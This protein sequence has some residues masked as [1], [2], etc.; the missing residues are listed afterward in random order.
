MR[1]ALRRF[2][3]L[4]TLPKH[5][6]RRIAVYRQHSQLQYEGMR[7]CMLLCS[8]HLRHGALLWLGVQPAVCCHLSSHCFQTNVLIK[9]ANACS[10]LWR[11]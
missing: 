7:A 10:H 6:L 2:I 8:A 4:Q 11:V 3:V 5:C 1:T 9:A